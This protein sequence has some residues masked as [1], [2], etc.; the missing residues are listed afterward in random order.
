VSFAVEEAMWAGRAVVSSPTPGITW[1]VGDAG[2]LVGNV[3]EAVA[4]L[5]RLCR[6][7]MAA[8][9]GERAAARIRTLLRPDDPWPL[10]AKAYG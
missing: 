6:P 8:A 2:V 4:A 10:I 7:G 1:L 5:H 9:E 3:T